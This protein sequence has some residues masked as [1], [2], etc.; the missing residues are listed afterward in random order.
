[1]VITIRFTTLPETEEPNPKKRNINGFTF[2]VIPFIF[3][4]P[5]A[6]LSL[7]LIIYFIFIVLVAVSDLSRNEKGIWILTATVS[8]LAGT[9]FLLLPLMF[10]MLATAFPLMIALS[11]L[12]LFLYPIVYILYFRKEKQTSNIISLK[13][14]KDENVRK[15]IE[16]LRKKKGKSKQS[17]MSKDLFIPK[18]SLSIVLKNLEREGIIKRMKVSRKEKLVILNEK[19]MS[20]DE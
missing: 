2:D 4:S 18:S 15:I 12:F 9:V 16:Y 3:I 17:E 13:I 14:S 8:A 10:P 1:M 19:F 6:I 20:N 11:T 7:G 5:L